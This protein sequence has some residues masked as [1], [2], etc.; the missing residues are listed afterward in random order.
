LACDWFQLRFGFN[1][2]LGFRGLAFSAIRPG[3]FIFGLG[4]A[5]ALQVANHNIGPLGYYHIDTSC[6]KIGITV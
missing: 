1:E 4:Q 3:F 5:V 2:L 6:I